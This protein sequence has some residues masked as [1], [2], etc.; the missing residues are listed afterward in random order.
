MM[1]SLSVDVIVEP[2]YSFSRWNACVNGDL[3]IV[4]RFT[5]SS[6]FGRGR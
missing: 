6:T 1:S 3:L 2:K 4:A 5:K